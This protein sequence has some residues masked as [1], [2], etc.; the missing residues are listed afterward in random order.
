M[1]RRIIK[2]KEAIQN[3]YTALVLEKHSTKVSISEI[4]RRAN[5]DR[6]TF[7]LHYDSTDDIINELIENELEAFS[8]FLNENYT[9]H[10]PFD[11]N[12]FFQC[13]TL[14][15]EQNIEHKKMIANSL[16]FESF[17]SQTKKIVARKMT[18]ALSDVKYLSNKEVLVYSNF[19]ASGIIDLYLSWFRKEVPVSLD[20]LGK[21]ASN[22][23]SN[24]VQEIFLEK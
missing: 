2:T 14:F 5:I 21:I 1:D 16:N 20:E 10:H 6:K 3:A 19:L 24:G 4:A 9:F 11:A 18:E 12:A 17:W 22:I 8:L 13:S 7:Y 15:I 23:V